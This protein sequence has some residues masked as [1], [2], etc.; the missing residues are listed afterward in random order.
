VGEYQLV[1]PDGL[2]SRMTPAGI[3]LAMLVELPGGRL[4]LIVD[5]GD[6]YGVV[7]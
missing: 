5:E 3:A 7:G 2:Q 6:G 4:D 1:P